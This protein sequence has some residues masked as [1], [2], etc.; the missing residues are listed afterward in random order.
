MDAVKTSL[1][2]YRRGETMESEDRLGTEPIGKLLVTPA[3]LLEEWREMEALHWP[4]LARCFLL[5]PL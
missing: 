1:C 5:F 3:Y 4:G 2:F